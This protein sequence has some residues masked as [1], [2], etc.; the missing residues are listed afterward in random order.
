MQANGKMYFSWAILKKK[1][2]LTKLLTKIYARV[3]TQE[4]VCQFR[5][6]LLASM[7]VEI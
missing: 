2:S 7:G 4:A 5:N 1:L 6:D 3:Q